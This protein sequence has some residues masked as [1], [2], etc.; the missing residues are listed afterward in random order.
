M[1]QIESYT[2][3]NRMSTREVAEITGKNHAHVMRDV[4]EM[5]E[6]LTNSSVNWCVESTTYIGGDGR[7][8]PMYNMDKETTICLLTGYD[9][10]AR[11][12]VIQRWQ[13][14]ENNAAPALP[15]TYAQALRALAQEAEQK[16]L[17]QLQLAEAQPAVEFFAQVGESKDAMPV[18]EAAKL[19]GVG[20]NALFAFLRAQRI[21]MNGTGGQHKN[22]P[23]QQYLDAGYFA[24][25]EKP[26]STPDGKTHINVKPVVLQKGLDYIRKRLSVSS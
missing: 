25:V 8:Y 18:G 17:L 4:R 21:F 19:L 20:P 5:T 1:S 2:A 12:K 10:G 24:V 6:V 7:P 3:P 23:Y 26:F 9:A 16:E 15:Q 13:S 22:M 14:L 11:M